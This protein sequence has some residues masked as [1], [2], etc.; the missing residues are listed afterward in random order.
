MGDRIDRLSEAIGRSLAYLLIVVALLSWME[1]LLRYFFRAP[2]VWAPELIQT[3]TALVFLFAGSLAMSRNQHIRIGFLYDKFHPG[4]RRAV[5][6]LCLFCAVAFVG[7]LAWGAWEQFHGSVWR[8]MGDRWLPEVT[9]RG[10]NVPLPP[11]TRG[12][13]VVACILFLLQSAVTYGRHLF[14]RTEM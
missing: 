11:V 8:F 12:L 4:A 6:A 5:S 1:V 9:G 3:F 10:W 14:G 13:L 7:G 2:T